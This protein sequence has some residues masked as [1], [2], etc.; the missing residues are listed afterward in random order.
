MAWWERVEV[1]AWLVYP[2]LG[3]A[4]WH[5]TWVTTRVEPGQAALYLAMAGFGLQALA[6]LGGQRLMRVLLRPVRFGVY[7]LLGIAALLQASLL[8]GS[9]N[10]A[11]FWGNLS[12][13]LTFS[14]LTLLLTSLFEQYRRPNPSSYL[15][16][17]GYGSVAL[18]EWAFV[19]WLMLAG[20]V[21]LQAYTIP[22]GLVCLVFGWFERWHINQRSATLMEGAGLLILLGTTL[23]Q[24]LG[25]QT[26]GLAKTWYGTFLLVL[27]IL[28]VTW[29]AANR[30][31]YYFF[32]GI[33]GVMLALVALL[34][35]PIRLADR[36]LTIGGTGV[37]LIIIALLLERK[38]EQFKKT[39]GEWLHRL[40]QWQ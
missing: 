35:D 31:R 9:P 28:A 26:D 8:V 14:G 11:D 2:T 24:A 7:G 38:R 33:C 6:Y 25:W 15:R 40:G 39:A 17:L 18:L 32:G 27:S 23:I 29:G 10:R 3:L 13:V 16:Y 1:L 37:A 4:A 22:V 5:S 30:L 36:W 19:L 12:W 20:A 21:Q 34:I